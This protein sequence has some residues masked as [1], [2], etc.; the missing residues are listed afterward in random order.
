MSATFLAPTKLALTLDLQDLTPV[1]PDNK[2]RTYDVR[3]IN[4][5]SANGTADLVMTDG[6][7]VVTCAQTYP[8]PFNQAGSAPDMEQGIVVPAG[9]KLQAK[10]SATLTVTARVANGVQADVADFA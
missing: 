5:G 6:T 2:V 9:W 1:T 8:V 4:V 7:N 10:A 3:F